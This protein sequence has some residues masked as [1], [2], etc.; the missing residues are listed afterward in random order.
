MVLHRY[1][2]VITLSR[3]RGKIILQNDNYFEMIAPIYASVGED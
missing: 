3:R 1:G 2:D